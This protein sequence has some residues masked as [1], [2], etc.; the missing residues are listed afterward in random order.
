VSLVDYYNTY[1]H[2]VDDF[3][4]IWRYCQRRDEDQGQNEPDE[5]GL[6]VDRRKVQSQ[7]LFPKATGIDL[8]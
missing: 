4:E 5:P 8:V 1:E 6:G 7:R 2:R 3:K